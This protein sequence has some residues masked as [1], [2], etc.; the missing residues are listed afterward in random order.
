MQATASDSNPG[1]AALPH[2]HMPAHAIV[3]SHTITHPHPHK[4]NITKSGTVA[5]RIVWMERTSDVVG[6]YMRDDLESYLALIRRKIQEKCSTTAELI[7]Q[8]RRNKIGDSVHVTPNEFRFTLIK[9]GV[10]LSQPLVDRVFQVFDSDRSGTMDFDEFATWIMNSEFQPS[11]KKSKTKVLTEKESKVSTE[12]SLQNKLLNCV[13]NYKRIFDDMKEYITFIEFISEVNRANM[14]L[15]ER[16]ARNIFQLLDREDKGIIL[17]KLF[18]VY[19]NNGNIDDVYNASFHAHANAGVDRNDIANVKKLIKR[20]IGHNT[21]Q[22]ENSF[23]HI[24]RGNNMRITYEEFRRGLLNAGIGKNMQDIKA[25]FQA[26]GG[27]T[28]GLISIDHF[29]DLLEPIVIDANSSISMKRVPTS[30]ISTSR[31]DRRLRDALR[32]CFKEVKSEIEGYDK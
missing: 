25:L 23:S 7:N 12:K 26:L 29:F 24:K 31:A 16:E 2:G 30:D 4:S 32:K 10:I 14:P 19:A 15:S 22:L 21:R 27:E 3:P 9:F 5:E 1:T 18:T 6:S 11:I 13:N 20:V 17:S 8:I 28:E